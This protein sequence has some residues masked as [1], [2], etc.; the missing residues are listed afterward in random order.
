MPTCTWY[1]ADGNTAEGP[2]DYLPYPSFAAALAATAGF[3]QPD[4][5]WGSVAACWNADG[6]A[7]YVDIILNPPGPPPSEFIWEWT[8]GIVGNADAATGGGTTAQLALAGAQASSYLPSGFCVSSIIVNCDPQSLITAASCFRCLPKGSLKEVWIYLAC[9]WANKGSTPVVPVPVNTGLPVIT[10]TAQVGVTLSGSN[11][12]WTNAPTGYTYQWFANGVAIGGATSNTFLLTATQL[13]TVIT[14]TVT[15]S[16][17]GG[18]G[19]PATS[20]ATSAVLPAVPVNTVLPVIT[21][22]VQVSYT[23]SGSNGTWTNTPTS[24]TYQWYAN[25][26]AIVGATANTYLLTTAEAGKTITFR[27]TA[28]NAGGSSLPATSAATA[29][30]LTVALFTITTVGVNQV[31]TISALTTSALMVVDWGDTN[32]NS[33]NGA[34]VPTHTYVAAGT[35]T[36][37]FLTPSLVTAMTLSDT[38]VSMDTAS[39]ASILNVTNFQ[40]LNLASLTLKSSDI[41]TWR[42]TTFIVFNPLAAIGPF[43]SDDVS[44][45]RP[46]NFRLY[47]MPVGFTGTFNS[48]DISFW[49]PT[50]TFEMFQMPVGFGGTFNS[51]DLTSWRPSV[52]EMFSMPA[53][54]AGTFNSSNLSNWNPAF[55]FL[56]SMPVATF[57]II[58][59]AGGFAAWTTM[60]AFNMSSNALTQAQVNQILT[61]YY[62]AFATRS[63]AGGTITL[64]GTN[65]AP[66]GIFQANCPPTSGKETAYDLLN[67]PCSVNPTHKWSTVATN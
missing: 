16:N 12:T 27:V 24:Y 13:G 62:T 56:Y 58:I 2:S 65:A 50:N 21:G 55:F 51:S 11:G 38:R 19:T 18:S 14:F 37:R 63:V 30:V 36:V 34:N 59:T 7:P 41:S 8:I 43:N 40:T 17:A 32:T 66:S 22:T 48:S 1:A 52:F 10:G 6:S 49:N 33:Y 25:G 39:M 47:S 26:V 53:G 57:T 31:F 28:I 23:L 35:Y 44:A 67:D 42:P 5:V 45:W 20:A 4:L 60:T 61:D 54:F 29:A 15:A 64:N 9:Q 3:T 46:T